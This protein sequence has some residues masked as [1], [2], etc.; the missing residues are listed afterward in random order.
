MFFV[1]GP[2]SFVLVAILVEL[3]TESFLTVV[4][5][6][7]DVPRRLCPQ[8][9][10]DGTVL[11]S[12]LLLDPVDGS[13]RSVLLGFGVSHLPEMDEIRSLLQHNRVIHA[14][15]IL[16]TVLTLVLLDQR[17]EG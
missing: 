16:A 13:M 7:T 17:N 11:L 10:F 12:W 6:V 8:F 4:S 1:H 3:N 2:H 14:I 15:V 5:P 9:S